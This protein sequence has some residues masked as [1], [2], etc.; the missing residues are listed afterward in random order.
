M[1]F[2]LFSQFDRHSI[3]TCDAQKITSVTPHILKTPVSRIGYKF[4]KPCEGVQHSAWCFTWELVKVNF[5]SEQLLAKHL[6]PLMNY[7]FKVL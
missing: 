5:D 1:D 3:I 6:I 2:D 4:N 7:S